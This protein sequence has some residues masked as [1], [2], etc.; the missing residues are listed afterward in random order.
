[1]RQTTSRIVSAL[2]LALAAGF[3]TAALQPDT[4]PGADG[5]AKARGSTERA[6][7]AVKVRAQGAG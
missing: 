4:P 3:A 2:L 1:M 7:H 6:T 5:I